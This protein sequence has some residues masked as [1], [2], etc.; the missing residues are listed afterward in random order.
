MAA[1]QVP[2]LAGAALGKRPP[3]ALPSKPPWAGTGFRR[4][5]GLMQRSASEGER[6]G[7]GRH[8]QRRPQGA[9]RC[10]AREE[11]TAEE[12]RIAEVHA[13]A[14]AAGQLNYVDPASGYTVLT[15]LAHVRRGECCGSA[16]RHVSG[17]VRPRAERGVLWLRL[18]TRDWRSP[19]TCGEGSAVAPPA[20]T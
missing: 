15:Q 20:D 7:A 12:L 14:C 6:G 9:V 5:F 1:R 4:H 19:P 17:E 11:L 2:A 8:S 3:A 13:A 16:C 18:Q 10:P